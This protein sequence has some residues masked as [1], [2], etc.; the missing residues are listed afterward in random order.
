VPWCCMLCD[1][2]FSKGAFKM[3]AVALASE[4]LSF[5]S[6]VFLLTCEQIRQSNPSSVYQV[7]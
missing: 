3:L 6:P 4:V 7:Y 5:P 1:S 2:N